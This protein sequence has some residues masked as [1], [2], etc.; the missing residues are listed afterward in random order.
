MDDGSETVASVGNKS[1][2]APNY[3]VFTEVGMLWSTRDSSGE[4][5]SLKHAVC[6]EQSLVNYRVGPFVWVPGQPQRIDRLVNSSN[7]RFSGESL[8]RSCLLWQL[9]LINSYRMMAQ[10]NQSVL[11]DLRGAR[12]TEVPQPVN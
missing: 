12:F 10:E 11:L 5:S 6:A 2:P 7:R 3:K 4:S 8:R 9:M 1:P